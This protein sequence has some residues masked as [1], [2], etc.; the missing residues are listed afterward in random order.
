MPAEYVADRVD[1][2]VGQ[3]DAV[4]LLEHGG[5]ARLFVKA[6]RG[7]LGDFDLLLDVGGLVKANEIERLP[8]IGARAD[9]V[10]GAHRPGQSYQDGQQGFHWIMQH[11]NPEDSITRESCLN[12]PALQRPVDTASQARVELG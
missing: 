1:F 2:D 5:G 6:R 7:D 12:Y 9:G 8:H 4:E 3:A 11:W 10:L